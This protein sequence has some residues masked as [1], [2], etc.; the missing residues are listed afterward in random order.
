MTHKYY[1]GAV[2]LGLAAL[3]L[4]AWAQD[5]PVQ[6]KVLGS[7]G[8]PTLVEFSATGRA[9]LSATNAAQVLR[10]QLPVGSQDELRAARFSAD[11]LGF[12][13]Q[14]FQ[15]YFK[16]VK[17]EHASYSVH[18][19][20]NQVQSLSGDFEAINSQLSVQPT[21]GAKEALGRCMQALRSQLCTQTAGMLTKT[22]TCPRNP[23]GPAR[24]AA[25]NS[26][27]PLGQR[28]YPMQQQWQELS[29]L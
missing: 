24:R 9:T 2:V 10:Q 7:D 27:T 1:A 19:R 4:A 3:P 21:L 5:G 15:Q 29:C 18:A 26:M 13:H 11:Q 6:R 28:Q 14:R 12:T 16:G 17:V 22:S 25:E 8:Q 23:S 20:Q